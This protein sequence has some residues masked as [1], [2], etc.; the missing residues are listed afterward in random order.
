MLAAMLVYLFISTDSALPD[1]G[2]PV[3]VSSEAALSFLGKIT[4]GAQRAGSGVEIGLTVTQE[5]VTSFLAVG[6]KL[7]EL[8]ERLD[9]PSLEDLAVSD[10]PVGLGDLTELLTGDDSG[11]FDF[12]TW[13]GLLRERGRLGLPALDP[14]RFALGL[15]FRNP[16]VRFLANGQVI[17]RGEARIF[18]LGF[19][20]R[21][22]VVPKAS[23]G[24]LGFDFVEGQLGRLSVPE[25]VVDLVADGLVQ[26]ILAGQDYAS[27]DE[28]AVGD[29]TLTLSARAGS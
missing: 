13:R 11:P 8:A 22:V 21:V 2:P 12:T 24:E 6:A 14:S 18:F 4:D 29:G 19:P 7:A 25:G 28:I 10:Q 3:P 15:R 20:A 23:A 1:D 27:I 9:Q 17:V 26:A 16:E 5:E